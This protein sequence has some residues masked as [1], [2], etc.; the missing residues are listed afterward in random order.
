MKNF[1]ML[2]AV[3]ETD[4]EVINPNGEK[5][6]DLMVKPGLPLINMVIPGPGPMDVVPPQVYALLAPGEVVG[7][8]LTIRVV[9]QRRASAVVGGGMFPSEQHVS[10]QTDVVLLGIPPAL[11]TTPQPCFI[12]CYTFVGYQ[13]QERGP[14][15]R[16]AKFET[17]EGAVASAGGTRYLTLRWT[18]ENWFI[19]SMTPGISIT[20]DPV[21]EVPEASD[22]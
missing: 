8:E 9:P 12:G 21:D 3:V 18:G 2:S 17:P 16:I 11:L 22:A 20:D 1:K 4:A 7:E 14:A 6:V 5:F 19:T 15:L 10:N 13:A